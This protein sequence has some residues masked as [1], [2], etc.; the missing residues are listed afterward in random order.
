MPIQVY[1]FATANG[2][3]FLEASAIKYLCRHR[4]KG[5]KEDLHKA[6]HFIKLALEEY[7]DDTTPESVCCV[8]PKL[9]P[10]LFEMPKRKD[11]SKMTPDEITALLER[12]N[13]Q[14][15]PVPDLTAIRE[16][17]GL[18]VP[19]EGFHPFRKKAAVREPAQ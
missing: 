11:V 3:P 19:I 10:D 13:T 17:E 2:I 1:K 7:Y 16:N 6:I 4:H 12:A 15:L 9:E 14:S 5:G 8:V 18:P